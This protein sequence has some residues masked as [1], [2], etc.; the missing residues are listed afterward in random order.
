MAEVRSH[1]RSGAGAILLAPALLLLAALFLWPVA[2]MLVQSFQGEKGWGIENYVR[3]HEVPVYYRV[4][5][6]TLLISAE[7]ALI[8]LVLGFPV[9]YMLSVARP[10]MRAVIL[11][12]ILVPFWTNLLVRT[13]GWIVILNEQGMMGSLFRSLGFR[14]P[15]V[16]LVHN[17]A[18]ILIGMS[19]VM[20]PYMI[21]PLYSVMS[22]L[23]P[24]VMRAARSLGATPLEAFRKVYLPLA[25]PGIM[26]GLLLVFTISLGFFIIPAILGGRT[27]VMLAQLIE[28]NI[29]QTLNWGMASSLSTVLLAVTLLL[30]YAGD[31]WFGLGSIWGVER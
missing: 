31:R 24:R 29:N 10:L 11:A 13:Y 3:L 30:L 4:L 18:G 7:T 19:Q 15:P 9:A 16:E 20:L 12:A 17:Q 28:F 25:R 22:R 26:A 6:R 14:E 2:G 1:A 8:C 27:G 5:T 23:D 21:L